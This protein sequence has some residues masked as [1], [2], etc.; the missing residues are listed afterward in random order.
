MTSGPFLYDEGPAP[1]H[2]G[3]PRRRSGLL[4]AIF[5]GT[6]VVAVLMVLALFLLK[7]SA[8]DQAEEAAGVFMAALE[9][10]DT[11]TA[12]ELLC[13]EERARLQ[14]EDV[15]AAYLAGRE[16]RVYGAEADGG[17]VRV[18]VAWD[19]GADTPWVVVSE[20][21]PRVCGSG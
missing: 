19:D 6:V 14:A 7:G 18:R 1:L 15:T 3:T 21:G 10:G 4:L 9:Q 12:H 16:G 2:T 11:E 5:G 17:I 20:D 13:D 8:E